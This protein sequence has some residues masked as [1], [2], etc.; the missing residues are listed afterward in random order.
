[1]DKSLTTT[2]ILTQ[3]E[4]ESNNKHEEEEDNI[5]ESANKKQKLNDNV[6][7]DLPKNNEKLVKK[8]KYALL[9]GYQGSGYFGLQRST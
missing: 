8:R 3:K 7:S 1:M 4:E 9:I 6:E 5:G 2:T